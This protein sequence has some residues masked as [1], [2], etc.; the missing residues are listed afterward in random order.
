M[1]RARFLAGGIWRLLRQR[2]A[3]SELATRLAFP[4][5]VHQ[6]NSHSQPNRYPRLFGA[7]RDLLK[8][9]PRPHILSFGCAA[10][11]EVISLQEYFPAGTIVGAELNRS[12]LRTC[13]QRPPDPR[14]SFIESS[15]E[16]I[17]ANGPYHA[18]FCMAVFTRRPHEV[19]ARRLRDISTFYPYDLFAGEVRFL[20]EQ[21]RPGGLLIVEHA[22]YRTED[23]LA[24]HPLVAVYGPG[25]APAKGSR[26]DPAGRIIE[27]QPVISRIFRREEG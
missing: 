4:R 1:S 6:D 5:Q 20:A 25:T 23:A 27:P 11:E 13:R 12:L 19:E 22:L 24:D 21:L 15:R 26:F 7:V 17:A 10:G 18:I 2:R 9:V 3:R 14:R 16:N 8:D